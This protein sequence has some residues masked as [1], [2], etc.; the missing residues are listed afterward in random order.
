VA[1]I[2][3]ATAAC[4]GG[5]GSAAAGAGNTPGTQRG[6]EGDCATEAVFCIGVVTDVG[7]VDDK[8]FNQSVWVGAQKAATVAGGSADYIET[9]DPKDYATNIAQF[10]E[11]R[12]DVIVAVGVGIADTTATAARA[13]PQ[14]HFIGVDAFQATVI[15]NLTGLVFDEAKA[16][17]MAGAL[18]GLLTKTKV[19]GAVLG[20][21][22]VPP[23]VKFGKGWE[24]GAKYTNP[25]VK[26]ITTYHPGGLDVAF[27]DPTWGAQS[28][29]QALDNNADVVFGAGGKTGNGAL[30]EVAKKKG[31]FCVGVDTDQWETVPEARPC[32]V[33]SAMKMIEAGVVELIAQAKAG[34]VEGGN[35]VGQVGLAPYHD[36][37][38][39]VPADV[40]A[41]METIVAGVL[42]GTI[43]TGVS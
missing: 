31:A 43:P 33:T 9:T 7:K 35:H 14:I 3:L 25:A 36:L 6:F 38:A 23:V 24:N 40:R 42:S 8:S 22:K 12:A 37:D 13:N 41:K 39:S 26:A 32:L 15:P 18:A 34:T 11:R 5:D 30:V 16:G 17:F 1:A 20:T 4:G 29:R 28:A 10:V 21:D 19:V 27:V 2:A